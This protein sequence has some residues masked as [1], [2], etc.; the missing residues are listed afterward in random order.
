MDSGWDFSDLY[1]GIDMNGQLILRDEFKDEDRSK[2]EKLLIDRYCYLYINSYLI[3]GLL[4]SDLN[5]HNFYDEISSKTDLILPDIDICLYGKDKKLNNRE[6]LEEFLLSNKEISD[7][8]LYSYVNT[9]WDYEPRMRN[10]KK[11]TFIPDENIGFLRHDKAIKFILDCVYSFVLSQKVGSTYVYEEK[12][13]EYEPRNSIVRGSRRVSE[14]EIKEKIDVLNRYYD[15]LRFKNKSNEKYDFSKGIDTKLEDAEKTL[16]AYNPF[17]RAF[18]S[19]HRSFGSFWENP[20]YLSLEQKKDIY[21]SFHDELPYDWK[22][23]CENE[24]CN[25]SFGVVEDDLFYQENVFKTICPGCGRINHISLPNIKRVGRIKN[26]IINRCLGD[27]SLDQKINLLS[28]LA[29]LGGM[30]LARDKVKRK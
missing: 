7:T 14:V 6:V 16:V 3:L 20:Y 25:N 26:R 15:I 12:N 11:K 21:F 4:L 9:I 27:T 17:I 30:E 28:E 22:I 1:Y 29:S 19:D 2:Y 24:E 18:C 10:C 5:N 23:K 8:K 13:G